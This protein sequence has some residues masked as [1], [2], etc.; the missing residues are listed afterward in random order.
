MVASLPAGQRNRIENRL[1]KIKVLH[2]KSQKTMNTETINQSN[3]QVAA[4]YNARKAVFAALLQGRHLS[5]M[6]CREFQ[7]ED[8]RTPVSHM[9]DKFEAEGKVLNSQWIKTPKGR[10]IKEYWL[11]NR[12]TEVC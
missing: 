1:G 10:S 4:R 12:E 3:E 11:T 2:N 7:I 5:Q 9:K 6:D 8:M